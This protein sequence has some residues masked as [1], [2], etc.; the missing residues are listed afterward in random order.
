MKISRRAPLRAPVSSIDTIRAS[1]D[2]VRGGDSMLRSAACPLSCASLW[3]C[4]LSRGPGVRLDYSDGSEGRTAAPLDTAMPGGYEGFHRALLVA[5][6]PWS[7][8]VVQH[9]RAVNRSYL[10][11]T[12]RGCVAL[13]HQAVTVALRFRTYPTE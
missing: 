12:P 1:F 5:A 9:G 4:L 8:P 3:G 13:I 7:V 2:G 10:R 6:C 11:S